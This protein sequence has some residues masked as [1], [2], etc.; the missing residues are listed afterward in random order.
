VAI[1]H[2]QEECIIDEDDE[3]YE[4]GRKGCC[5]KSLWTKVAM[6]PPINSLWKGAAFVL[7]FSISSS[8]K[9]WF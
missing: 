4:R 8:S 9:S 5:G 3:D 7:R 2:P 6:N 1:D